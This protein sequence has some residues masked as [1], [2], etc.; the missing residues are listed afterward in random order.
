MKVQHLQKSHGRILFLNMA[1]A[2][3]GMEEKNQTK[4]RDLNLYSARFCRRC[5]RPEISRTAAFKLS[6]P[7][8]PT[9]SILLI[10]GEM[11]M[12]AY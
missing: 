2:C 12:I 5:V 4:N 3:L 1:Q 6:K 9:F 10:M 7:T 8:Q 11:N